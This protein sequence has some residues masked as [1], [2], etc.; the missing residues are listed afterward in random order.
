MVT[1]VVE[2]VV[3][4]DGKRAAQSVTLSWQGREK[5]FV[6]DPR[7]NPQCTASFGV[8]GGNVPKDVFAAMMTQAAAILKDGR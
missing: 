5:T 8:D 7:G 3:R 2:N 6:L 1:V 4:K